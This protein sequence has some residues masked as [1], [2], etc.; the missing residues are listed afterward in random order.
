MPVPIEFFRGVLGVIALGCAYMA[1]RSVVGV[2]RGLLKLSRLYSWIIRTVVCL[3]AIAFRRSVDTVD[4]VVW[5]LTVLS[6]AIGYWQATRPPKVE[7]DLTK[8]MFED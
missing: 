4:L 5:T 1:A 2:R 6:F 3:A 8:K 7:E